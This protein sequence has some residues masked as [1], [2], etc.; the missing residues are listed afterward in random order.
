MHAA[1]YDP[2]GHRM[3]VFGGMNGNTP[4]D[5]DVWQL[6]FAGATVSAPPPATPS[7]RLAAAAPNPAP[8]AVTIDF[9]LPAAATA[10]LRIY[11]VTGRCVRTL[12]EGAQ[13]AGPRSIRWDRTTTSGARAAAGLYFYELRTGGAGIARRVVLI[14]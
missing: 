12:A 14:D 3:L 9:A 7:L 13:P 11:D 5:A 8:D 10:S 1:I 6:T 4:L 2:D